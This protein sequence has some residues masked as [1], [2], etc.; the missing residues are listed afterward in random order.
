MTD[1]VDIASERME[2]ETERRL[3]EIAAKAVAIPPG[4]PGDCDLCGEWSGRLVDGVCAPCRDRYRL[5]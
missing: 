2:Q 4:K 1:I 3:A 5:P